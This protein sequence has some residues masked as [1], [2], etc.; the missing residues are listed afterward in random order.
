[1]RSMRFLAPLT[2]LSALFALSGCGAPAVPGVATLIGAHASPSAG[3]HSHA[4]VER[5]RLAWA[6]CM[7]QHGVDVPDPGQ[8]QQGGPIQVKS[9]GAFEAAQQ[10]CQ[11][12]LQ[13]AGLDTG[14]PNPALMDNAVKFAHCMRQHGINIPDPQAH[15][16]GVSIQM[17]KDSDANS[18]QF[19]AA[20]QACQHYMAKPNGSGN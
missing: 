11:S 13:Q 15:G 1:M 14:T 5:A 4:D 9:R 20:Q 6:Q 7:R 12:I 10:A 19:Q 3:A 17:P 18:P 2:A 8:G 16:N